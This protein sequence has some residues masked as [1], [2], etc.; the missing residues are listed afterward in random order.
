MGEIKYSSGMN[1]WK[2]FHIGIPTRPV[3]LKGISSEWE[4]PEMERIV[5]LKIGFNVSGKWGRDDKDNKLVF[6]WLTIFYF[7]NI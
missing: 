4:Q 2:G 7:T 3:H 6:I 5:L 1:F